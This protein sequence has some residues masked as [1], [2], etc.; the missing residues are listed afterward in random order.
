MKPAKE[1]A[2]EL[3][4]HVVPHLAA[5]LRAYAKQCDEIEQLRD[6]LS[7]AGSCPGVPG[8]AGG[9]LCVSCRDRI[10]DALKEEQ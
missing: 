8:I 2:L 5:Y 4:P 10:I 9:G 6:V 3:A 1:R 7:D